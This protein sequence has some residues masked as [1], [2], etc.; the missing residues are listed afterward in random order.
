LRRESEL[1]L[2]ENF[3]TLVIFVVKLL[4]A[5]NT[6]EHKRGNKDARRESAGRQQHLMPAA[7]TLR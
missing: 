6:N 2:R 3:V 7:E 5:K 4:T 1:R